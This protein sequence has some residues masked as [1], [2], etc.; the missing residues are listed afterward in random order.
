[1]LSVPYQLVVTLSRVSALFVFDPARKTEQK[2]FPSLLQGI[3]ADGNAGLMQAV[4]INPLV[5]HRPNCR[6]AFAER[7][8]AFL[9]DKNSGSARAPC[10]LG[11][12]NHLSIQP[13]PYN[14][15]LV[16]DSDSV[17]MHKI[18][19]IHRKKG[20]CAEQVGKITEYNFVLLA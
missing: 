11:R 12:A 17:Q 5:S 8:E 3:P 15:P 16:R 7:N 19:H 1:M 2:K 18:L 10:V 20:T 14:Y 9:E 13:S 4:Q 6:L